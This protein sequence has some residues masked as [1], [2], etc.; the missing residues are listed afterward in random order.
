M[1]QLED[2]LSEAF[3]ST[4]AQSLCLMAVKIKTDAVTKVRICMFI[5][6]EMRTKRHYRKRNLIIYIKV[7]SC[8]YV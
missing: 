3:G 5:Y 4:E 7:L 1:T 2:V 8:K 6:L